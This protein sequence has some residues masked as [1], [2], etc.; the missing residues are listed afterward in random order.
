[1]MWKEIFWQ[2]IY[3]KSTNSSSDTVIILFNA[4]V[5]TILEYCYVIWLPR[6]MLA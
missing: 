1:M 6:K 2:I 4:L 3:F 5:S